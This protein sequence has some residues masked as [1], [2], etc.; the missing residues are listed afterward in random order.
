MAM[1]A[2]AANIQFQPGKI[3]KVSLILKDSIVPVMKGQK[4]DQ[5][6]R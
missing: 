3:N 5:V 1:H 6:K 4:Q 2:R